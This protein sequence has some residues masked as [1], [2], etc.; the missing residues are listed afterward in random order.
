MKVIKFNITGIY[1]LRSYNRFIFRKISTENWNAILRCIG[2]LSIL[3]Q[4]KKSISKT[5]LTF[6]I[7]GKACWLSL[8]EDEFVPRKIEISKSLKTKECKELYNFFN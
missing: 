3:P 2:Y 6:N 5:V 1:S 4:L 7:R 8:I